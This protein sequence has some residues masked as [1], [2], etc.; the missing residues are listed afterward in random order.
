[1]PID[2]VSRHVDQHVRDVLAIPDR[3]VDAVAEAQGQDVLHGLLPEEVVDAEDLRLVEDGVDGLVQRARRAQV[4][5][6][7]LLHDH[8]RP[9][10]EPGPP[11]R[12]DDAAAGG[13]RDR[14]V[15]QAPR[16][17]TELALGPVDRGGERRRLLVRVRVLRLGAKASHAPFGD[18]PPN[19]SSAAR[20]KRRNASS[21][22]A[23]R[24]V[25]TMR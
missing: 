16:S 22:S 2:S 3:L 14:E 12:P 24:D 9:L 21:F 23:A 17:A 1:V 19:S 25:P 15:V 13:G 7:R 5:P 10:G 20:A 18:G 6:E 4:R 8:A 11:Q